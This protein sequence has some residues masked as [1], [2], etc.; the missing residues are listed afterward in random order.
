MRNERLWRLTIHKAQK[1][2]FI[3]GLMAIFTAALPGISRAQFLLVD[4]SGTN[5]YAYPSINAALPFAGQGAFIAV[6]GTCNETVVLNGLNNLTLGAFYGQTANLTGQLII[7]SSHLVYVYGL[8]ITNPVG[9]GVYIQKS[10]VT[11]DTV[12]SSGN[13][14]TGLQVTQTSDVTINAMGT[15]NNNQGYGILNDANSF[16]HIVSWAGTTDIS[17]NQTSG[18]SLGQANFL[19]FG[20]T[21]IANNGPIPSTDLR[22]A[23]DIRGG[24]KAQIGGLFGANV[25]E[26]NPNGGVSLQENAE[27][28]FWSISSNGPNIIRNNGPFGVKAGFGSQVT[29]VGATV[30][31]HTGPGVD[32]Y[33]HSQLYGTSQ[34]SGLSSTQIENNATAGGSLNAGIRVDGNSEALLRGVTISQN[35]GPAILALVN[36]SA[37]FAGVTFS[38]NTS[39]IT[40]DAGSTMVSD[41]PLTSRIPAAG[42]SCATAH[43][44]GNRAVS[45]P[46]PAVPDIS[47]WKKMHNSYQ[48]RSAAQK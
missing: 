48:Q 14:G 15:F 5:P 40:C 32:I 36:S 33:A 29:L 12:S 26:N 2:I 21:H 41:L 31:G 18:V 25:I 1:Y 9:E 45:V 39:V 44:L 11:L 22:V 42:V 4:C 37:D 27:I 43:T 47:I 10:D 17:N 7:L 13:A 34:L 24:G 16:T 35:N 19:T 3:A 46:A 38:G 20:N 28:S 6:T 30:S 23:I 8:N